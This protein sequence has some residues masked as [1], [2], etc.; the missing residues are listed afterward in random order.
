MKQ[1]LPTKISLWANVAI[2]IAHQGWINK[3]PRINCMASN[4]MVPFNVC[5]EMESMMLTA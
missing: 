1:M 3:I 5:Q 2:N 4:T